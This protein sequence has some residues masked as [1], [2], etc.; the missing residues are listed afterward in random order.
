LIDVSLRVELHDK[1]VVYLDGPDARLFKKLLHKLGSEEKVQNAM[2]LTGLLS[3]KGESR[4][5]ISKQE[6]IRAS[7]LEL[8]GVQYDDFNRL[9]DTD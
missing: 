9:I 4:S 8:V 3:Q 5:A 1:A 7:F 2:I 6:A